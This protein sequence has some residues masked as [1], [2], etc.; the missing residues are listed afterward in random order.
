M[1]V[2]SAAVPW[3]WPMQAIAR[4]NEARRRENV[5]T[6]GEVAAGQCHRH[7]HPL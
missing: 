3:A 4:I 7:D 5:P 2:P 1:A 6:L